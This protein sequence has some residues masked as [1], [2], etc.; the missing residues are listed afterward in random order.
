MGDIAVALAII[1]ADDTEQLRRS[2]RA[3][4]LLQDPARPI[5]WRG[6]MIDNRQTDH[7]RGGED[8]V[9]QLVVRCGHPPLLGQGQLRGGRQG[10]VERLLADDPRGGGMGLAT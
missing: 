9:K 10:T 6:A 1:D 7:R 4:K 5:L 3:G 2:R 8:G